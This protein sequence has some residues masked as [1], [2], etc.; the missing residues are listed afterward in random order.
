VSKRLQ[1]VRS[2]SGVISVGTVIGLAVVAVAIYIGLAATNADTDHFGRMP[3]P[4]NATLELTEG[5]T[6]IYYAQKTVAG[7]QFTAPDALT[8]G[9]S[10]SSG[11]PIEINPRGEEPKETD[12]TTTALI[13][14]VSI[15]SDGI[16]SVEAAGSAPQGAVEPELTFGQG[17]LNAIADRAKEI[18]EELIGPLGILIVIGLAVLYWV[19]RIA[20]KNKKDADVYSE[21]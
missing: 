17:P 1:R 16:Y 14:S 2:E 6:E 20:Q 12:G 15:P 11:Q 4:G 10:D 18:A 9:I 19:P 7:A 13:A 21:F 3:V 5:E 8:Y